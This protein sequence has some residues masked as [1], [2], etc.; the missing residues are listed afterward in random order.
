MSIRGAALLGG[1]I[2]SSVDGPQPARAT[3][4][5]DHSTACSDRIGISLDVRPINPAFLPNTAHFRSAS[6][7]QLGVLTSTLSAAASDF[8]AVLDRP[9]FRVPVR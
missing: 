5:V 3:S 6:L 9:R 7:Q 4:L 2:G 8:P 1:L